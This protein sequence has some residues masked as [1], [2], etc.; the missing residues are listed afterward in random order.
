M[1]LL[2]CKIYALIRLIDENDSISE[3]LLKSII[4]LQNNP[5]STSFH[6]V[7]AAVYLI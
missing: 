7:G 5:F 4:H 2:F 1:A 6:W 3:K